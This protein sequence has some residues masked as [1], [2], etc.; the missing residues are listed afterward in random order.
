MFAC[1]DEDKTRLPS[2]GVP[3]KQRR[4]HNKISTKWSPVLG[5]DNAGQ[6]GCECRTETTLQALVLWNLEALKLYVH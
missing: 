4:A 1:A 6:R 5:H 2:S 3:A